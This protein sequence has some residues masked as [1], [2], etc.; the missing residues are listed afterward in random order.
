MSEQNKPA[1]EPTKELEKF[2]LFAP[3]PGVEGKYARLSWGFWNGSPRATVFLNHPDYPKG[4]GIL[5]AAFDP[6]IFRDVLDQF[7][8]VVRGTREKVVVENKRAVKDENGKN[9][10]ET[11][12]GTTLRIGRD[13]N[14]LVAIA[15]TA[16]GKPSVA[17]SFRPSTWHLLYDKEGNLV[18]ELDLSNAM[19][20]NTIHYLRKAADVECTRFRPEWKPE[21]KG[22]QKPGNT[23]RKADLFDDVM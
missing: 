17:F 9:T 2:Q 10:R 15:V 14:G 12:I 22:G 8:E 5:S 19:A 18:S 21:I 11:V 3:T 4:E 1:V 7:E 16:E 20:L 23:T 13:K 6:L